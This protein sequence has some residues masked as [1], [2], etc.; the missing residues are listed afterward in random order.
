MYNI[1][2]N[3]MESNE[4]E[5]LLENSGLRQLLL[6]LYAGLVEKIRAGGVQV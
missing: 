1:V 3:D 4:K 5:L 6:D 2:L